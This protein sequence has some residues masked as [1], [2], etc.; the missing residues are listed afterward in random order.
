MARLASKKQTLESVWY[1]RLHCRRSDNCDCLKEADA[2]KRLV[3]VT[4]RLVAWKSHLPQRSRRSKASGTPHGRGTLRMIEQPQR[5][6]RS[7]ASGTRTPPP[8]STTIRFGLKEADARKRLVHGG[9]H[10]DSHGSSASKKQTL[11]SV[12]YTGPPARSTS[13]APCM[14]QRSRRSKASGTSMSPSLL[15][16]AS[17]PQRSRRSK[18]SG[19]PHHLRRI[20]RKATGLKEADARKRLVLG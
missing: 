9:R 4:L 17:G 10:E 15:P 14:P 6:R 16:V 7:K 20:A 19:T 13:I 12:W 3:L 5:S 18:A 8:A 2:R 1:R 11:E